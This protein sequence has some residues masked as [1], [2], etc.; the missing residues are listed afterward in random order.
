VASNGKS[1][2]DI[3]GIDVPA[4][5][6]K[7]PHPHTYWDR[8]A[9]TSLHVYHYQNQIAHNPLNLSVLFFY[10]RGDRGILL[11][12]NDAATIIVHSPDRIGKCGGDAA[13]VQEMQK[14]HL[15]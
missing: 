3:S 2:N 13:P 1:N 6:L 12:G 11:S 4:E 15:M 10:P 7:M 14:A 9:I 5:K 8:L